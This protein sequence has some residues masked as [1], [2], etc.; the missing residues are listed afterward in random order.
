MH[1]MKLITTMLAGVPLALSSSA[2]AQQE[3]HNS[4][5]AATVIVGRSQHALEDASPLH[6]PYHLVARHPKEGC[7][8]TELCGDIF[9]IYDGLNLR[10]SAGTSWQS[11]LMG[12]HPL[13]P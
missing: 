4:L 7:E 12:I 3:L 8:I 5:D 13:R 11:Q 6:H 2:Y 1:H 10:T 9:Y